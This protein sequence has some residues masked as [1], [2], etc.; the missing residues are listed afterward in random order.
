[1]SFGEVVV[2]LLLALTVF[3]AG[4]AA[5]ASSVRDTRNVTRAHERNER[6][7]CDAART[8]SIAALYALT[9]DPSAT[10]EALPVSPVAIAQVTELAEWVRFCGAPD[11]AQ[12]IVMATVPP[13]T[14]AKLDTIRTTLTD[15]TLGK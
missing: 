2:S 5:G 13:M 9:P 1:M 12:A 6:N 4:A 14:G 7:A 8:R 10:S 3:I 15:F 11:K